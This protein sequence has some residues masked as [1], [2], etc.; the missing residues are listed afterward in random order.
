MP[1]KVVLYTKNMF[2]NLHCKSFRQHPGAKN[3]T[4]N[5]FSEKTLQQ[6]NEQ[7]TQKRIFLKK[8]FLK[9]KITQN[10]TLYTP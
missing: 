4:K 1:G 5:K 8:K 2:P 7:T 3:K 6:F 9:I 10:I